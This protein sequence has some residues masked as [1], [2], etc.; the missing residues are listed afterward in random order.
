MIS[1]PGPLLPALLGALAAGR[2]RIGQIAILGDGPYH[3]CHLADAARADQLSE[4]YHG[5]DAALSVARCDDASHY[6]PLRSAPTLRHGWRLDLADLDELRQA[7]DLFYPAALGIWLA[8]EL[9]EL[10]LLDLRPKLERQTGMYRS[11]RFLSAD[12]ARDLVLQQCHCGCL[13]RVLWEIAER[14]PAPHHESVTPHPG[15][16]PLYCFEPCNL[17]VA[18][19]REAVLAEA[20]A[21]REDASG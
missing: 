9:G 7:L 5:P 6:R 2:R 19:A 3:L 14:E 13:K 15:E 11:A 12:G 21:G 16:I 20:K 10:P 8:S 18:R 17:L 4:V 1:S